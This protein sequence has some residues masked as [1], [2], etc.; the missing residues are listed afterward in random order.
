M[1]PRL[2]NRDHGSTMNAVA[3]AIVL[4]R[5]ND[6]ALNLIRFDNIHVHPGHPQDSSVP[7]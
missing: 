3:F 2:R 5:I 6:I 7:A 1:N 4:R